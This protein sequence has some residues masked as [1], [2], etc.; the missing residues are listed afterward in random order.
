MHDMSELWREIFHDSDDYLRLVIND[1]LPLRWSKTAYDAGVLTS[2]VVG[3]PYEFSRVVSCRVGCEEGVAGVDADSPARRGLYVCGVATRSEWRGRGEIQR[4]MAEQ[5]AAAR[6]AGFDFLFL[7]PAN[8]RLR[9][10]YRRYGYADMVGMTR[11]KIRPVCVSS[12]S[13]HCDHTGML[14]IYGGERY[15]I[16]EINDGCY[17]EYLKQLYLQK[18]KEL[19]AQKYILKS[20]KNNT[21]DF[22]CKYTPKST[23]FADE[24]YKQKYTQNSAEF[25]IENSTQDYRGKYL[26][27]R[28]EV[29]EC[30][31]TFEVLDILCEI[32]DDNLW[33]RIVKSV[34]S[35]L[36]VDSDWAAIEISVDKIVMFNILSSLYDYLEPALRIWESQWGEWSVRHTRS[37]WSSI[38]EDAMLSGGM[39]ELTISA[40]GKINMASC[41]VLSLKMQIAGDGPHRG[42]MKSLSD[43]S[44]EAS[45]IG[46]SLMLD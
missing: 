27:I 15:N 21:H 16:C 11:E 34:I 9:D 10:F 39:M 17:I 33:T 23:I 25:C 46:V 13:A 14:R 4:L 30:D 8:D 18:S 12:K 41:G 45:E 2:M 24:K 43:E 19:H 44:P 1:R 28:S 32:C 36:E 42:M 37:Q 40:A 7:I 3:I 38:F 26:Q 31:L 35:I 22:R 6:D 20:L 29:S 5:E